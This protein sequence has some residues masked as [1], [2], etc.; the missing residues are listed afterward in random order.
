MIYHCA[1]KEQKS[2]RDHDENDKN[3]PNA[4][5]FNNESIKEVADV[6]DKIRSTR[7]VYKEL[8]SFLGDFLARIDHTEAEDGGNGGHL[9]NLLQELWSTY[10]SKSSS[11]AYLKMSYLVIFF[12]ET[13]KIKG[14]DC[15]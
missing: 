2:E 6:E 12:K 15:F 8:K 13:L 3:C 11:E 9:G 5:P 10:Q 1:L 4:A 7:K 14:D